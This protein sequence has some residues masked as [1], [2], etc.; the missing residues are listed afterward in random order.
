MAEGLISNFGVWLS[1]YGSSLAR[2]YRNRMLTLNAISAN[3]FIAIM[4]I[5]TWPFSNTGR[6]KG[7]TVVNECY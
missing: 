1:V 3:S 7:I 2:L 4:L 6:F 5:L